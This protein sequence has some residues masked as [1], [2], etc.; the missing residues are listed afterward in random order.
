MSNTEQHRGF[1]LHTHSV[2]SD[3]TTRPSEIAAEAARIGLSGFALTDHDTIDGWDEAREAAAAHGI[4]FLPGIEITTKFAG[5]SP[6]L[7]G[8]GISPEAGELFDALSVVRSA[9]LARA[10][11]MVELIMVDYAITWEDVLGAEDARTVGRPH[12]ADAL[13]RAGYFVD[14]SAAF[15]ELLYP[16]SP[17]YIGTLTM[18]TAEAIRLVRQAGGVPV[19]AHPAANRQAEPIP[20]TDL[21][22][23]AAA[24]LWGIE[25]EHP[26]NR[27]EWVPVLREG[28]REIGLVPTGSSDFHGAGKPNRLGDFT[29]PETTVAA[30]RKMT[31]TPR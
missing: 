19:I 2:Y 26:E 22:A 28:A 24:G 29:T 13:V 4:D 7:L 8:Y 6:H 1:D 15:T 21:T 9:R 17:Y 23:L 3:G 27:P 20:L 30:I 5:R 16:G 10:S 25:L 31:A 14:R 12:I 11:K 18:D